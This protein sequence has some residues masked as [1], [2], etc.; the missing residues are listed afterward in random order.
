MIDKDNQPEIFRLVTD[1]NLLSQYDFLVTTILVSLEEREFPVNSDFLCE[2]NKRAVVYISKH[3]GEIRQ[4][5]VGINNSNHC[6]PGHGDVHAHL[7]EMIRYIA[8][9]WETKD[10]IHLASYALWRINWI[11]PFVEGNGRTARAFSYFIICAKLNMLLPGKNIIPQQIRANR[12]PY[13]AALASADEAHKNAG[14]V[15]VSAMEKYL[16][17]LLTVQLTD[18]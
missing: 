2:L 3:P 9:N 11:H 12:S 16:S 17:N 18:G 4:C 8:D 13:Y 1:R 7:K 5:P 15:D 14:S 6:P 10:A